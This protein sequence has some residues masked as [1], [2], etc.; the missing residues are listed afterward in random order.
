MATMIDSETLALAQQEALD[1]FAS[2]FRRSAK[3][4]LWRRFD[5]KVM[6]IYRGRHGYGYCIAQ[7]DQEQDSAPATFSRRRFGSEEEAISALW[8]EQWR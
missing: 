7:A 3:G 4:N 1:D 6:T 8:Q 2:G 5:G